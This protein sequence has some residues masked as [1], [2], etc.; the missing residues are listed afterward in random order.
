[1]GK[2][3][4]SSS[5]GSSSN[6]TIGSVLGISFS[7]ARNSSSKP[8][9]E[10]IPAQ[11]YYENILKYTSSTSED[12]L[13]QALNKY[14][15]KASDLYF[16][17]YEFS[18]WRD[19]T[20]VRRAFHKMVQMQTFLSLL[21]GK[22]YVEV[23]NN[24]NNSS[25][26]NSNNTSSSN[27][28]AINN[29]EAPSV[30]SKVVHIDFNALKKSL[31][32]T[33]RIDCSSLSAIS[34]MGKP[35]VKSSSK[36]SSSSSDSKN[37]RGTIFQVV[38]S[39]CLDAAVALKTK[40]KLNPLML[41]NGSLSHP[42]GGYLQGSFAQEEDMC[43]RS[44]LAL[45]LDDPFK[46]DDGRSWSYPLPEFGGA[47]VGDCFVI[48]KSA[49]DG[50]QFLESIVNISMLSMAAYANPPVE[51]RV[52][53]KDEN[54][55]DIVEC[56]LDSKLTLSMK[57]KISSFIEIALQKGHDSLVISAIGA[58]AYSNPTF[59][60]ATLFKEVLSSEN[61]KDKFKIV[62]FSIIN[63]KNAANNVKNM[64][65]TS[66]KT[67]LSIFSNVIHSKEPHLLPTLE[68]FIQQQK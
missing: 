65:G 54:G 39:D 22:Y 34:N 37:N 30:E 28:E 23:T 48:R 17:Y 35:S 6:S 33:Q 57:K 41:V 26:S 15:F 67:N 45:S 2:K 31:K 5:S 68:E 16:Y 44:S 58:G 47:Y 13:I 62:L 53:G 7:S 14:L 42:G 60:I 56:F 38:E 12:E 3:S 9:R 8:P 20:N 55:K 32:S 10:I 36:S 66:Q 40:L 1:M 59:H 11:E 25:S 43:R 52:I 19:F 51:N 29:E 18:G 27:Q 61:Y 49:K 50:Y 46:M 21:R 4:N 64:Y 63:D 24:N